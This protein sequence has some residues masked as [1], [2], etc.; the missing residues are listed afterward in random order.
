MRT[1]SSATL[2]FER[3]RTLIQ[4]QSLA[5]GTPSF[6]A[7]LSAFIEKVK[8]TIDVTQGNSDQSSYEMAVEIRRD[9]LLGLY[10]APVQIQSDNPIG[11]LSMPQ[12]WVERIIQAAD[13]VVSEALT[14][15]LDGL[16]TSLQKATEAAGAQASVVTAPSNLVT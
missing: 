9:N 4:L 6:V 5:A 10:S 7:V 3:Q 12:G 16:K 1:V 13:D 8:K 2:E 15:L 14:P 11:T